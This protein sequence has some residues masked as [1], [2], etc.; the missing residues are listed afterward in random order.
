L[1]EEGVK[2]LR[3]FDELIGCTIMVLG[4]LAV[5]TQAVQERYQPKDVAP[6]DEWWES[7]ASL[8]ERVQK[9]YR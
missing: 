9:L 1:T 4:L 6:F 7:I 8:K 3:S 5:A 2:P